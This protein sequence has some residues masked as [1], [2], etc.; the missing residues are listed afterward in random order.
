MAACSRAEIRDRW[1]KSRRWSA[2]LAPPTKLA[3]E[4]EAQGTALVT[5]TKLETVKSA[6]Q[7]KQVS[8]HA[9]AVSMV[10]ATSALRWPSASW[11]TAVV[12]IPPTRARR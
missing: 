12:A 9:A 3:A 2:S 10:A 4:Q 6:E 11:A 8:Q 1:R 5:T 7:M